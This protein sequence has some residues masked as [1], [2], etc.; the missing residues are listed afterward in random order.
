MSFELQ[1]RVHKIGDVQTIKNDFTKRE[2]IVKT[3]EQYPQFIP[4]ELIKDKT[5]LIDAFKIGD[6]IKVSFDIRGRE[7]QDRFFINLSAWRVEQVG[8][9]PAA[10]GASQSAPQP[11]ANAKAPTPPEIYDP[12]D[13]ADDDLPF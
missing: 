8:A 5:S 13:A 6:P 2:F 10:G 12:G 1:G 11:P 3:D 4:F 9:A 7:W